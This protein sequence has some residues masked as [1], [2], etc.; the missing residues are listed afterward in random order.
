M[1]MTFPSTT[2]AEK[3]NA[4][5]KSLRGRLQKALPDHVVNIT[6]LLEDYEYSEEIVVETGDAKKN[7]TSQDYVAEINIEG[8]E[9]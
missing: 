3:G 6:K 5:V 9:Q 2:N 4:E 8:P 7:S 1:Q